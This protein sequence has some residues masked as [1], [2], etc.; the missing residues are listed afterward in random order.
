MQ[1]GNIIVD[2]LKA[3]QIK[4][5]EIYQCINEFGSA[6]LYGIIEEGKETEIEKQ[7]NAEDIFKIILIDKNETVTLLYAGIITYYEIKYYTSYSE[8]ELKIE[9]NLLKLNQVKKNRV[10]QAISETYEN[11]IK[12]I[13][14][15]S[16]TICKENSALVG[17]IGHMSVQYEETDWEYLK[18][19]TSEKNSFLVPDFK[20]QNPSYCIGMPITKM[21]EI[22]PIQYKK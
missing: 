6:K 1:I 3:F 17:R 15:K 13:G 2:L 22:F 9:S 16:K 19:L 18:R 7:I 12:S 4:K 14:E 10:F 8:M 20:F 5:C 21:K 11:I